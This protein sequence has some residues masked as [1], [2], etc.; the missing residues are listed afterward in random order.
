MARCLR[1][2]QQHQRNLLPIPAKLLAN[3]LEIVMRQHK[4]RGQSLAQCLV[5]MVL[6][7]LVVLAAFS[8]FAWVQRT[9]LMLQNQSDTQQQM[10]KSIQWV[11]E[12]VQRAGAPELN[13]DNQGA[14]VLTR[15]PTN[16]SG[17]DTTVQ[18]NQWRSLTPADCQGHEASTQ[19]WLQDD[20]RR[21]SQ[22]ELSCKDTARSNTTYQALADQID[23]MRLRYAERVSAAGT[24]TQSQQLQWRTASQVKDWQQIRAISLCLQVR[25]TGTTSVPNTLSCNTQTAL[26]NGAHAWRVVL[27]LQH[28][29][30]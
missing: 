7:M 13:L 11:R 17:S 26:S 18:L 2:C 3:L 12:R 1:Y 22:R 25:A 9:Q 24:D 15:L 19:T 30:P 29:T 28:S 4:Q 5:G 20:F 14:A 21:N 27:Y 10:H 16:L 8:A 23:D 6:S